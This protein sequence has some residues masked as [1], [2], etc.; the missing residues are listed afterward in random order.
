MKPMNETM[1]AQKTPAWMLIVFWLYVGIP[2]AWG[3]ISTIRK[4]MVLF[5]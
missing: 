5:H 1:A 3:V 4:A 2:L